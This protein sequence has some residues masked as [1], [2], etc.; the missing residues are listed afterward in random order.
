M[1]KLGRNSGRARMVRMRRRALL[2]IIALLLLA[3]Y[4]VTLTKRI[5][6][7]EFYGITRENLRYYL[8][9]PDD[10]TYHKEKHIDELKY[11]KKNAIYLISASCDSYLSVHHACV[12][13]S[14]MQTHGYDKKVY[15]F[16]SSPV[17]TCACSKAL[18][19]DLKDLPSLHFVTIQIDKF[20]EDTPLKGIFGGNFLKFGLGRHSRVVEYLKFAVLYKFGGT[21]IDLDMIMAKPVSYLGLNWAVLVN[22]SQLGSAAMALTKKTSIGHI[23][24][25]R[26][27]ELL[28]EQRYQVHVDAGL[29][30]T[31]AFREV[32]YN[33]PVAGCFEFKIYDED[34]FYPA[35]KCLVGA[36]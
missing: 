35:T 13:E 17:K 10:I 29:A 32:C 25:T 3:V 20:V 28:K 19:K 12:I 14:V 36:V 2:S 31:E 16:F 30:L 5:R 18:V 1:M 22:A 15:V 24:L 33:S 26:S 6:C 4:I 27:I 11:I 34:L 7:T 9:L 8:R 21:I 23:L